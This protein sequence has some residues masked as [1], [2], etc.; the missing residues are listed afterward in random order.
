VIASGTSPVEVLHAAQ[1]A[2][3]H[4]FFICVGREN[5]PCRI[6]RMSFGTRRSC[7]GGID[8]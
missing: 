7:S 3:R 8:S 1:P 4:P 6:R 2:D 5:E